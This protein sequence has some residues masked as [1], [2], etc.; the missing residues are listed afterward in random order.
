MGIDPALAPIP[1]RPAVHYTMGGIP[2]DIHTA[3]PLPGSVRRRRM[4]EHRH[5]WREPAR[6]EFARRAVRL[7][8]GGGRRGRRSSRRARQ[9]SRPAA[10]RS[11]R[12][13]RAARRL[14]CAPNRRRRAPSPCCATRWRTH[15]EGLR[16]LPHRPEMQQTCDNL[17]ELKQR[18]RAS[19]WTTA[20]ASG[21]PN[22]SRRSSWASSSTSPR[23]WRIR[24]ST[25]RESRGAHQRLDG[26]E[27]RDDAHFLKHTAWPMSRGRRAIG[28]G[29]VKITSSP[30]GT[31]AYGAA[32][33]AAEK[34]EQ[35]TDA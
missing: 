35:A 4:F 8:Q 10:P 31:R 16:H 1:V 17:A 18:C 26:F 19:C 3:S 12:G 25:R 29:P 2:A 27:E 23:P 34:L 11:G 24:R 28:Y 30:P 15:G 5:P 20:R 21:T 33:E 9:R 6:L 32:G 13:R 22:G 14:R 7:R